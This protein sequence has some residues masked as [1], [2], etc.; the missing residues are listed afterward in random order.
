MHDKNS[1]EHK[2]GHEAHPT[3][4]GGDLWGLLGSSAPT[5]GA[6]PLPWSEH[7]EPS[8]NAVPSVWIVLPLDR[9]AVAVVGPAVVRVDGVLG[10]EALVHIIDR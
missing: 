1:E 6:T 8:P 3:S 4:S 10:V 9:A 2:D 7:M 5:P